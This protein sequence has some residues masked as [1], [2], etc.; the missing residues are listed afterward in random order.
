[1]LKSVDL[2]CVFYDPYGQAILRQRVPIVSA[3]MGGLHPGVTKQFRLPFDT[4]P[5]TWNNVM[6]QLVIAGITFQ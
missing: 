5:E 3:Q 2:N 1:V 6:P 4:V